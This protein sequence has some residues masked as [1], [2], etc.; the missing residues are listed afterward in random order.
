L[1]C[2]CLSP[3]RACDSKTESRR[4]FTFGTQV[5]PLLVIPSLGKTP[6]VYHGRKLE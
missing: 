5:S 6:K 3:V 2:V 1:H 4:K